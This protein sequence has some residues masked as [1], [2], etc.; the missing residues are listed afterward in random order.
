MPISLSPRWGHP[1][2]TRPSPQQILSTVEAQA[3]SAPGPSGCG[4]GPVAVPVVAVPGPGV[5]AVLPNGGPPG[6][7]TADD[8]KT[9]LIVN[10]LPQSMSQEELRSLFGSLGD[11]ESCKLVRD[12]VTGTRGDVGHGQRGRGEVGHG[13]GRCGET[14]RGLWGMGRGDVGAGGGWTWETEMGR[15]DQ[16]GPGWAQARG[17]DPGDRDKSGSLS[18]DIGA[19]KLDRRT[20]GTGRWGWGRP[21]RGMGWKEASGQRWGQGRGVAWRGLARG[22]PLALTPRPRAE[23]GLRL[24]Q[25]RG[26]G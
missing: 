12:K 7:P 9:N 16:R 18:G 23:P 4:P 15:G 26:G 5:A 14:G 2:D 25:L 21:G 6:P 8:S 3:P 17:W 13:E 22:P 20:P 19:R 10:Y 1:G 11:I 24:R